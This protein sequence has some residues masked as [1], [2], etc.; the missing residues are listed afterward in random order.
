MWCWIKCS[1]EKKK[2]VRKDWKLFFLSP[3]LPPSLH[4]CACVH[5]WLRSDA[6]LGGHCFEDCHWSSALNSLWPKFAAEKNNN[7][8]SVCLRFYQKSNKS[9][10][11]KGFLRVALIILF[12]G[13]EETFLCLGIAVSLQCTSL[14]DVLVSCPCVLKLLLYWW[15][16]RSL[17]AVWTVSIVTWT[18]FVWERCGYNIW[19]G[20]VLQIHSLD[21]KVPE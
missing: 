12:T 6:P 17:W 3:S 8:A 9:L 15:P 21:T 19:S 1:A 5:F 20:Q 10:H 11:R 2:K 18:C 13:P 16:S 7:H 14:Y 4:M